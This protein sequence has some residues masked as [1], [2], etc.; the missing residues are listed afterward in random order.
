M[1][2]MGSELRETK[3]SQTLQMLLSWRI[4]ASIYKRQ[5]PQLKTQNKNGMKQIHF[6]FILKLWYTSLLIK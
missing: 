3:L 5:D 1:G 2:L 6:L 4:K